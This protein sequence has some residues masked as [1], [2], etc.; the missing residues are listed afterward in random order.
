MRGRRQPTR[1]D[2]HTVDADARA[3]DRGAESLPARRHLA[4]LGPARLDLVPMRDVSAQRY[5]EISFCSEPEPEPVPSSAFIFASSS[6][7]LDC[8]VNCASS[9]SSCVSPPAV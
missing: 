7:T 1:L 3:A 5:W 8:E 2:A 9:R 6:S 4:F